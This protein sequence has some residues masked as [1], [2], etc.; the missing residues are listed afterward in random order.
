MNRISAIAFLKAL[1][2]HSGVPSVFDKANESRADLPPD[3]DNDTLSES[4]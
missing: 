2:R 1:I 3:N 4:P